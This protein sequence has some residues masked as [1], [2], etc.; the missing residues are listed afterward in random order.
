MKTSERDN[1]NVAFGTFIKEARVR[2][3]I[4]QF[5]LSNHLGVT[6]SYYSLIESGSRNVDLQLAMKI[7]KYLGLDLNEFLENYK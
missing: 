6:Q 7:C 4:V 1:F 5:D 2:K 3:G